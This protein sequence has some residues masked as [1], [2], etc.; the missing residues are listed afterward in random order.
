M[1]KLDLG[2]LQVAVNS[3]IIEPPAL[4]KRMKYTPIPPAAAH[5]RTDCFS[6]DYLIVGDDAN[7]LPPLQPLASA[8]AH[9]W[10][11]AAQRNDINDQSI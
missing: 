11:V 5:R 4:P 1:R 3:L 10:E 9:L 2:Q 8:H 7:G 6:K